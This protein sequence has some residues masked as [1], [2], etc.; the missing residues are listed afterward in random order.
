MNKFAV[1]F[2]LTSTLMLT[3]CVSLLPKIDNKIQRVDLTQ[4][5]LPTN[6]VTPLHIIIKVAKPTCNEHLN[7]VRIEFKQSKDKIEYVDYLANIEWKEPLPQ[8]IQDRFAQVLKNT[9]N[10]KA[11][12]LGQE[13]IQADYTLHIHITQ[14]TI[15]K[16]QN[17]LEAKIELTATLLKNKDQTI[18]TQRTF[19]YDTSI[20][21]ESMVNF[22]QALDRAF[23]NI[24][25]NLVT[26]IMTKL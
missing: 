9:Y 15:Y 18:V 10:F 16:N 19:G 1:S 17:D 7:T 3:S 8:L 13:K 22:I 23:A 12:A 6:L 5:N 21:N 11:I 24:Q 26:W 25:L 14:F 2:I 4:L 20:S